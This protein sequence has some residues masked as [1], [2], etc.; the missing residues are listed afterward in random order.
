MP[1]GDRV[2]LPKF[3]TEIEDL[4]DNKTE[5]HY[6][7]SELDKYMPI[8]TDWDLKCTNE[9]GTGKNLQKILNQTSNGFQNN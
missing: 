6:W 9:I 8:G 4:S 1:R 3:S 7:I 5:W 2:K